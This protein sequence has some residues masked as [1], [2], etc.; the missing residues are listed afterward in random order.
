MTRQKSKFWNF[1]FSLI[2][3]GG[4]MH[5]GFMKR[6]LTLMS[7]FAASVA[8][9]GVFDMNLFGVV[10]VVVW[11]YAFFDSLNL[12]S[13]DPAV[14]VT[15]PDTFLLFDD[16]LSKKVEHGKIMRYAGIAVIVIGVV[17]L[18]NSAFNG[19]WGWLF[20]Y[21]SELYNSVYLIVNYVVRIVFSVLIILFGVR[22]M[23]RKKKEVQTQDDEPVSEEMHL[24]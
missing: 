23:S 18:W 15:V 9:I 21:N 20:S 19:L 6:G 10:S 1:I 8:L 11:F 14:F 7:I 16:I 4:Q 13:M 5:L 2:P 12:N 3:G 22:L 17:A 24:L